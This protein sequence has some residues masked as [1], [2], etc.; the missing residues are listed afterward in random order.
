MGQNIPSPYNKIQVVNNSKILGHQ[1]SA[2]RKMDKAVEDR[3]N[4]SKAAWHMIKNSYI[5]RD[6]IKPSVRIIILN[7]LIGT[8]MLYGLHV[9]PLKATLITKIQSFYSK[10]YK[11]CP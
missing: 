3:L 9:I 6:D 2:D 10:N 11:I 4:K 8:I 1:M 7:S 5:F